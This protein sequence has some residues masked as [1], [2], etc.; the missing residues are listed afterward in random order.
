MDH[1]SSVVSQSSVTK[2]HDKLAQMWGESALN[3]KLHTPDGDASSSDLD[4]ADAT[5]RGGRD[6]VDKNNSIL[7]N[8]PDAAR[9]TFAEHILSTRR[10]NVI[11]P[12]K[13]V[14][15]SMSGDE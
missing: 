13:I 14:V 3:K 8:L 15:S 5:D 7:Q 11:D 4:S 9:D 10:M 12:D 6:T 2:K 1:Q